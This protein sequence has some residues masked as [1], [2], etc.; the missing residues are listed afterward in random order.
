MSS[1]DGPKDDDKKPPRVGRV[2][3]DASG[4]AIWEWATDTGKHAIDSTSRLLKRLEL[5]GLSI[6]D[7]H[8]DE[9]KDEKKGIYGG[10][11]ED[12]P[13]KGKRQSFNPYE[14]RSPPKIQAPP[15]TAKSAPKTAAKPAATANRPAVALKP[16]TKEEQEAETKRGLL[17]RLFGRKE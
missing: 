14:S 2:K 8:K 15:P 6:A 12:D 16:L 3:H 7:D 17:G 1:S 10:P 11:E 9:K 13:L 4:R 5:P